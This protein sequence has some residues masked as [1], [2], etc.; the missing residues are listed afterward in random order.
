MTH[1]G[2]L[3]PKSSGWLRYWHYLIRRVYGQC[4]MSSGWHTKLTQVIRMTYTRW[5]LCHLDEIAPGRISSGWLMTN[6]E[7]I[8]M[9]YDVAL[10]FNALRHVLILKSSRWLSY[11]QYLI[12]MTYGRRRI[13][14]RWLTMWH[15]V[16]R[17]RKLIRSP[18]HPD[19]LAIA[20]ISSGWLVDIA[21]CHPAD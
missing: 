11:S 21:G 10:C 17:M 2:K 12:R 13:S 4:T 3:L 18:S 20:S 9:T 15:Y 7:F 19:D 6:A 5:T 16:I 14:S 8:Q 1:E